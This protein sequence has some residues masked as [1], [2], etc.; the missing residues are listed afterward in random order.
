MHQTVEATVN[1]VA[2]IH[3]IVDKA[4]EDRAFVIK[5]WRYGAGCRVNEPV[6]FKPRPALVSGKP[7][8]ACHVCVVIP[9][10]NERTS[11]PATLDA[12]ARQVDCAGLPLAPESFE[13]VLL[14]NNCTDDSLQ[15]AKRWKACHPG[16]QLHIAE[17][18]LPAKRAHVG[19]A[20]SWLM[21]TAWRR[22]SGIEPGISAIL[23]TD[24]DTVVAH[25]WIAQN[26]HAI[27][28]GACAVGGVIQWKAGHFEKLS[29]GVQRAFLADR[30]YQRLQAQ[31]E[32]LLDPQDGDP[33]PRHLEHFGA[34]LACTPQAYARAGGMPAVRAL[35]D[36]ALVMALERC[37]ITIRHEPKVIVFT[38]AR[39][40]GR[41]SIGCS[42]QL[43]RWQGMSRKGKQHLVPSA[44]WLAYRFATLYKLRRFHARSNVAQS[45]ATQLAEFP[46]AWHECMTKARSRYRCEPQFLEAI[47]CEKLMWESYRGKR[48]QV[49]Q[50]ANARLRLTIR[51][52]NQSRTRCTDPKC[53]R[54]AVSVPAVPGRD[55]RE[56]GVRTSQ[57][58]LL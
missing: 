28:Q 21:D 13:I 7:L 57:A 54:K 48:D 45:K 49:I 39:L 33:W 3:C 20:R 1:S 44:R 5:F 50:R 31:L 19:T 23:S 26:L 25:D 34:S 27:A 16:I 6:K 15:V 9:V 30:E 24:A 14:L 10:R 42:G 56:D 2:C 8:A 46:A 29:R 40:Q 22:L 41:C 17:R 55:R 53:I 58:R 51:T 37:G 38:S 11:L 36:V 32:H 47:E 4:L 18:S 52:L 12:L 35:E 43:R